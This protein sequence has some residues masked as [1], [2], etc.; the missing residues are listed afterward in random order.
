MAGKA[1]SAHP[2]ASHPSNDKRPADIRQSATKYQ[3]NSRRRRARYLQAIDG[4][5][6]HDSREQVTWRSLH[7]GLHRAHAPVWWCRIARTRSL[8]NGA[9]DAA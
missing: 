6:F 9:G 4:M 1:P 7:E 8:I 3:G 2:A 5:T